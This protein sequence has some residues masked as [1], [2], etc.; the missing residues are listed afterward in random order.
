VLA[1][2]DEGRAMDALRFSLA[3]DI[4]E[5]VV[6]TGDEIF[7]QTLREAVGPARRLWHVPSADKVSDL[8]VAGGVGI[9]VLDVQALHEAANL[10]IT[11]IKR[12]FP[13]LVVVV[14]GNRGAET[15]L[16]SLISDG[17]VYRF[18]HKPMSPGRARL[19]ADAAVKKYDEQ[20][21]RPPSISVAA[22]TSPVNRGLLVG[23]VCSALCVALG[24]IWLL[25]HGS[26]PE[27]GSP[28]AVDAAAPPP[29]GSPDLGSTAPA[30]SSAAVPAVESPA[31]ETS[32]LGRAAQ[33]LA[34]NRLTAPTGDNALELYLQALARDPADKDARGGLAEV[35]ERLLARAENA[36]LEERLDEAS[37]AIETARKAGVERGRIAFLTAQLAKAREQFKNASAAARAKSD[38][39]ASEATPAASQSEQFSALAT[40]RMNDG[41]LTDPERDNAL[42]Y[43]Q[44]A[45]REDP[46]SSAALAAKQALALS[47]LT[48]VRGAIDRRD[49]TRAANWLEG[50]AGIA[51]PTNI[52]NLKQM[53][54]AARRQADTDAWDQLMKS[55]EERVQ[56]DRLI[57][58]VNDSAA[59]YVLTLRSVDPNH[60]GLGALTQDLGARLV[61]KGRRALTLEQYDAA[62]SW[63]DQA[64]AIG[65]SAPEETAALHDLEAATAQQKF[66]AN[67]VNAS[68]LNVDKTVQPAYPLKARERGTEGWVELEFTVAE[69]GA[70]QD[71]AVRSANPAGVFEQAAIGAL[72]QWRYKPVLH[73]AQAVAQRARIRIRFALDR[74][75]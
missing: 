4:V 13:D 38:A 28:Q 60:A 39:A 70:V 66:M 14:A 58:P 37:L 32:L 42:F 74:K 64:T 27:G 62:R 12:Q 6:L 48:A 73:D 46:D 55:A 43:V 23:A 15:T 35:H 3:S 52:E 18:I 30:S 31:A 26:H 16:A 1:P 5:L 59:Y 9:L 65:Y 8:L 24:T 54:A 49:F 17:T 41:H 51:A 2:E 68:E 33:A 63:L 71:V 10:F 22:I 61:V 57:E 36:L 40:Q 44:E 34:A 45:L 50:A 11:E 7:L 69:S 19:F 20:R 47:L 29:A 72:S 25:R 67:V 75:R 53:L 56:E 21:K